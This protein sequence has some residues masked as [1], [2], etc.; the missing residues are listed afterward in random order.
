MLIA[1]GVRAVACLK[2]EERRK[3]RNRLPFWY[4]NMA[5]LARAI[6]VISLAR[7]A[8]DKGRKA[9]QTCVTLALRLSQ[10]IVV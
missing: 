3:K 4:Y 7:A 2:K 9:F 8:L 10:V 1:S 5:L 6:L